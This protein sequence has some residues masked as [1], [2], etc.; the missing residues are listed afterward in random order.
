MTLRG[1]LLFGIVALLAGFAPPAHAQQA[2]LDNLY[3]DSTLD[4]WGSRYQKGLLGNFNDVILPRLTDAE[5]RRLAGMRIEVP[6]RVAGQEPF[7]YYTSGPPW[8]ITMSANSIKLFDDLCVAQAWLQ[9]NGYGL[10]TASEYVTMLK[11]HSAESLGG[12]YPAALDALQI[13]A[14]ALDDQRVYNIATRIFDEAIFFVLL[15]ELGHVLYAHPGYG[16]G[17]SRAEARANE[18]AAD[19]FALDMMRR[20]GAEPTS[21]AFFFVAAAH[22]L[23]GR[24]DFDN[25]AG[26]QNFLA[27]ATHPLTA[28]RLELLATSL[29]Q[30]ADLFAQDESD[31]AA[32][33]ARIQGV[34]GQLHEVAGI[35]GDPDIQRLIA[36]K[37]RATKPEMLAPRRAGELPVLPAARS[38]SE[39]ASDLAF[40]GAYVGEF[41]DGTAALPMKTILHRNGDDVTGEYYYGGGAGRLVGLIQDGVFYYQWVEGGTSGYGYMM[42][43]QD[44]RVVNGRWGRGESM[45][46]GGTWSGTKVQ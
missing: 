42:A 29:E 10:E 11:Y 36:Q 37:G 3:D 30:S 38:G 4:Y 1:V 18:A 6:P 2:A 28:D 7:A 12:S 13:P 34:A 19:S 24:G 21:M 31:V 22:F 40:D 26:Y 33:R 41:S 15:H 25:E 16:P 8:V 20:V 5:R 43:E 9:A 27:D 39:A 46:D 44:G 17:V 45:D 14:G 35:L 23:D 32:S